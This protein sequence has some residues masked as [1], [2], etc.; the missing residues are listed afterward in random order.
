MKEQLSDVL[1]IL[2]LQGG[3]TFGINCII[4]LIKEYGIILELIIGIILPTI[5]FGG[6]LLAMKWITP[7]DLNKLISFH[8]TENG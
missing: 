3:I 2:L 4:L 6:V 1:P 8:K 5:L 7:T